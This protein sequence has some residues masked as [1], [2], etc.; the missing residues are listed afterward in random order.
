MTLS[1][2]CRQS[3]P[4]GAGTLR[5]RP[6]GVPVER[7]C[8]MCE[9]R[10]GQ[11]LVRDGLITNEQL[12]LA[13][14]HQIMHGG[15]LGTNL[16][17]L[18]FVDDAGLSGALAKWLLVPAANRAMIDRAPATVLRKVSPHVAQSARACPFSLDGP[19]L[20]VAMA[21]PGDRDL[22]AKL[23]EATG[24]E[25]RPFIATDPL[26]DYALERHYGIEPVPTCLD[27]EEEIPVASEPDYAVSRALGP[28]EDLPPL[29]PD[30][31]GVNGA[32]PQTVPLDATRS[33]LAGFNQQPARKTQPPVQQAPLQQPPLQSPVA[34]TPQVARPAPAPAQ[35][36]VET[37]VAPPPPQKTEPHPLRIDFDELVARLLAVRN[38]NDLVEAVFA[39]LAQDFARVVMALVRRGR[40]VGWRGTGAAMSDRLVR[41]FAEPEDHLPFVAQALRSG[42]PHLASGT[43]ATLGPFA[44]LLGGAGDSATLILPL[45]CAGRPVGCF[46]ATGGPAGIESRFAEYL[47]AVKKLDL[48]FQILLM[49]L[50]VAD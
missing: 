9:M 42:M 36:P 4:T 38:Q 45:R 47:N 25:V 33:A 18:G 13:L 48:T 1:L 26:I 8:M 16:M 6:P 19:R 37:R 21:N 23:K 40:C 5:E 39:Y 10:L 11:F 15:R 35:R 44:K 14:R 31:D 34:F 17:T 3:T 22:V 27:L 7:R 2:L 43:T 30:L 20:H 49:R 24:C 12:R 50:R 41:G 46:L 28:S 32:L 29:F